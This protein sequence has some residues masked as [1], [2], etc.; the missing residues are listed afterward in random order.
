MFEYKI[1]RVKKRY[2]GRPTSCVQRPIQRPWP[3]TTTTIF[4]Y[5][6]QPTHEPRGALWSALIWQS[7]LGRSCRMGTINPQTPADAVHP[8]TPRNINQKYTFRVFWKVSNSIP[9]SPRGLLI[10]NEEIQMSKQVTTSEGWDSA[11]NGSAG[12]ARST[13][14]KNAFSLTAEVFISGSGAR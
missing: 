12:I 9:E 5:E 13:R 4:C 7:E 10:H 1:R 6:W 14:R 8:H 11:G 3:I 2:Q